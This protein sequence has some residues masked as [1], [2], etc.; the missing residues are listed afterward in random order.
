M[1]LRQAS[2]WCCSCWTM[3]ARIICLSDTKLR[4]TL[5]WV[6]MNWMS[7]KP[8]FSKASRDISGRC[9]GEG[10]PGSSFLASSTPLIVSPFASFSILQCEYI[11][12]Y[13][14]NLCQLGHGLAN[15]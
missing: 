2:W 3:C 15:T 13:A 5:S 12:I 7:S 4:L 14:T 9:T 8:S 6:L 1:L 11:S 10:T